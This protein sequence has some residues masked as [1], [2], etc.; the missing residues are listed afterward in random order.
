MSLWARAQQLPPESLQKVRTIYGDHFPIEVR[1][2]LAPWIE[3]RIWTAEPE[4]QQR[5][6]VDE[7]VQEIQAHAD[8]MLSPDMF[9]TKMKLLDAAKNFHMQYSHAPHELYAYMRRSLALEMDVI[10]NAMGTP[11]VAQ[12]QTER[13]YSELITGLQTVR[14]KVSM[15][16]EEIR[17]LQANIESFSLQYHECLKNKGHMNYLQQSMTNERRDLVACLRVQIEETERKL[18]ALVAQISQSQMELV[19]HMKE[20]IANLRQLQSQV[21]D[22][23]LIKWKREQQLS[24]NGVPM[25]SNLNTIQEWCEL[26]ADLIWT[27]RQQVNNVARINTKTIVELRQPHLAEMLDEMSK[28]VTGLLSTLVTSTFVIEKQPPQVMKTNTRFTATVRLLV[29]G[30][31]NV[32]MTPPRVNVVIISEQQ[33]QLLLKSETQAGKGKQ[34][35]ECGDILNNSGSMEY[36]PTSRQL[37]VSFRNMQLRKIKRAEKKG[38]ESVMDEKLTLLFQSQFNVGGGELVFQVWTLSLPVVVIVHGNQEPHGWATVTWDNAFSPPGRVPFAVPDKVTWGQLAETLRIKFCSATGGDLSEDNLR[39]LAEKIFSICAVPRTSLPLNNIELNA[40]PVSWTQF[41]KDALPE[42]NFTF[43]EW[44]YMVV[45][46][47]RDYLRTLWCDHLIMGFIQKK[48]AEEMLSKCPAGT[49][50]L[51]FSDSELG[52]ITIAWVGEGNEVF[53]LQ[54]F[55]SRDLMLRSLADRVLDLTQLQFLYPNIAKDDVFSKYYTKPENEMLKNGYVKPV[56]VTTLP[57]YMSSSPAYAHSPDSHRN[58]PSVQSSYFSAATPAQTDSFM[59]SELFEQIR[60][61]EP[62]GMDEFDIY[63]N[64]SMK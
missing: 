20:N 31:L 37:S 61:F 22:E 62:D 15:V 30:Q 50:L 59:D 2:C 12:P 40:M 43:W 13:K 63:S 11:Y 4:D 38:T 46:V 6:F 35:V 28:Q 7:L 9:V 36:Q 23:E 60:A 10:Q 8:L 25:Q 14:Q 27:T 33:A 44:F 29:G 48:Q 57:P 56:L 26:L 18:N 55:T 16:G 49:F 39:F 34:P 52:G 21:L 17:S 3:S 54:P 24:G 45:K 5:F 53:S 19:D 51:R 47:T 1:H 64:M 42:R 32:Y 58:T 41:C